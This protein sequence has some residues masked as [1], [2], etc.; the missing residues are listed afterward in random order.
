MLAKLVDKII[1]TSKVTHLEASNNTRAS[2]LFSSLRII[3]TTLSK[4]VSSISITALS[5]K[6]A[7]FANIPND[8]SLVLL[9]AVKVIIF[10]SK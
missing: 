10:A 9:R 8:N 6:Q 2:L 1:K 4:S 7:K 5:G 3:W